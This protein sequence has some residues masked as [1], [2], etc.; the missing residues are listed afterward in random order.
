MLRRPRAILP[1]VAAQL[2][3]TASAWF[4]GPQSVLA[5]RNRAERDLEREPLLN[6]SSIAPT[7]TRATSEVDESTRAF[8]ASLDRHATPPVPEE[9]AVPASSWLTAGSGA[10]N[11]D[12][13]RILLARKER[14]LQK[15]TRSRRL[16]QDVL[17][18][19]GI[20]PL[21]LALIVLG[22]IDLSHGGGW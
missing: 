4:M 7:G 13:T 2:G 21:G 22:S 9:G 16:Y 10:Q 20:L 8:R 17:V 15:R 12:A 3:R 11:D 18:V 6:G 14:Q 19:V 1:P 5:R